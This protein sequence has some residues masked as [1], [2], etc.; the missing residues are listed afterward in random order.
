MVFEETIQD[1]AV[2]KHN[3]KAINAILLDFS[4]ALK[5]TCHPSD[6]FASSI[7]MA[8]DHQRCIGSKESLATAPRES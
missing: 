8:R 5:S 7:I 3:S 4:K 1:L 6:S 2:D